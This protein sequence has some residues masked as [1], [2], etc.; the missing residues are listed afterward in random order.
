MPITRYTGSRSL[1]TREAD[2]F[3]HRRG[4]NYVLRS[5]APFCSCSLYISKAV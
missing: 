3:T 1:V 2:H 5:E 4:P